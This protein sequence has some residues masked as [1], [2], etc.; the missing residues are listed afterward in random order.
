M[1]SNVKLSV[2]DNG[3]QD[4]QQLTNIRKV[5]EE[6]SYF[7]TLFGK[8]RYNMIQEAF[9]KIMVPFET[10]VIEGIYDASGIEVGECETN[11][12]PEQR[13]DC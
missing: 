1:S 10:S 12:R 7:E 6:V 3:F 13:L 5:F 2:T 9:I 4:L 8:E 11:R